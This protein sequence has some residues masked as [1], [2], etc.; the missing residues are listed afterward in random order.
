MR[1][2]T[3]LALLLSFALPGTVGAQPSSPAN[4]GDNAN[5]IPIYKSADPPAAD[6]YLRGNLLGQRC[7][8]AS[9][10]IS[11]INPD[12]MMIFCND[13]RAT[14]NFDDALVPS[15]KTTL[16][17]SAWNGIKTFFAWLTGRPR[18]PDMRKIIATA[19]A[20]VGGG[21]SYD[22][23]TTFQ[24]FM[25][26]GGPNDNTP[27]SLGHPGKLLGLQGYSDP[28]AISM[29]DGRVGVAYIGFTRDKVTGEHTQSAIFFTRYRDRNASDVVHDWEYEFTS[30]A[31]YSKNLKQGQFLDKVSAAQAPDGTLY[32]AFTRFTGSA[33]SANIFLAQSVDGGLTWDSASIDKDAKYGQ[34]AL[35]LVNPTDASSVGVLWRTFVENGLLFKST[36]KGTKNVDLFADDPEG[37]YQPFDQ[38]SQAVSNE[39]PE[40]VAFRALAFPAADYTPDGSRLV[41]VFTEWTDL[42]TGLPGTTG[43]PMPMTVMKVSTDQGATWSGRYVLNVLNGEWDQVPASPERLGFFS[44]ARPVGAQMMPAVSCT[45]GNQ[46]LVVWKQSF[47]ADLVPGGPENAG[48]LV[49]AG[50][51]RRFDVRGALVT[52]DGATPNV[53]PSFQISRYGYR[54]PEPNETPDD[55]ADDDN[56]IA[57]ME[58][59]NG[60][61]YPIV[62]DGNRNHTGGGWMAFA[63][64]YIGVEKVRGEDGNAAFMVAF[65]DNRYNIWPWQTEAGGLVPSGEEWRYYPVFMAPDDPENAIPGVSCRNY[66]S[67]V[68]SVMAARVN[69]SELLL[70]AP[71]NRKPF[72]GATPVCGDPTPG[73]TAKVDCIEFPLSVRNNAGVERRVTLSLSSGSFAKRAFDPSLDDGTDYPYPL[74]TGEVTIY[75]YSSYSLN[76]YAFDENPV[77]VTA[78]AWNGPAEPAPG[79]PDPAVTATATITFN[80]PAVRAAS[81][82]N[83]SFTYVPSTVNIESGSARSGSARSGSA[84]SGSAR[85]GSARSGSARSYPVPEDPVPGE[86]VYDV[87]DY[88]YVVTANSPDDAGTYLSLFNIDPAYEG[89]YVFQVFVTKPLTSFMTDADD[90]CSAF[91]WTEG[92]LI[93]HISDPTNPLVSGSARSGSA[94][95]GSARSGSARSGSARSAIPSEGDPLV[96]NT[97]FTLGSSTE[98]GEA[99]ASSTTSL[100][101]LSAAEET[102]ADHCRIDLCTLAAPRLPNE[103]TILVR[104]YQI[105]PDGD[106][107]VKYDPDGSRTSTPTPPSVAVAEYSCDDPSCTAA[108]G[109]D[110]VVQ[111]D[112]TPAPP[113][114]PN[115]RVRAGEQVSFP[116]ITITNQGVDGECGTADDPLPCGD[117]RPHEWAVYASTE[118]DFAKVPR[119]NCAVDDCDPLSGEISGTVKLNDDPEAGPV[120]VLL[121][122]GTHEVTLA[123]GDA[124]EAVVGNL[125]I[126]TSL[127][128]TNPDGTG[129][130]SL[131]FYDDR[132]RIVNELD[133]TNNHWTEGPIIVEA[134]GYGF[135]GLQSPCSG[136]TCDKTG[137]LPLAWQFTDGS[138]PIDSVSTL[139]RLKFYGG[140]PA[141]LGPDGY[142]SGTILASSSPDP[143]DLT[144][145]A[146]G[147]QYFPDP[148]MVRLQYTWQFNFD[149]TGLP[150]GSC[151]SMY[152]AVPDTGQVI[153]S[154]EEGLRPFGPFSITPR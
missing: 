58:L 41:A 46:C 30:M 4:V 77:T 137:T 130:Y 69:T 65:S 28:F 92:A 94:R 68:Q 73:S 88:T 44:P 12:H 23:G 13:Y 138:T 17:A 91:N 100:E 81:A 78:T 93:G 49:T 19:E 48:S 53:S 84:R 57:K 33:G 151:Y 107:P 39:D 67:R 31:G 105:K 1:L 145:G 132:G 8:E 63:G 47:Q 79:E 123:V 128:R 141:P 139:P 140:C 143:T 122:T 142:P 154:T 34:A 131:H 110:L 70:N 119:W 71:T 136:M 60:T 126:P 25:V 40:R 6:D 54:Q 103:V 104:A 55:V 111:T 82:D 117:A 85:S 149:A 45:V 64:D 7:N 87:I 10:G 116:D 74:Q 21:V 144:S 106:I 50:L 22:G 118:P 32:I 26:P 43:Y 27:A 66:G 95:S 9:I 38:Y 115:T 51:T 62:D 5:I 152:I 59:P 120:T 121:T 24:G 29:K 124:E 135:L 97:S 153:G 89:S 52:F 15:G 83:P 72:E 35:P 148:G 61:T 108:L 146:S 125:T 14:F 133:E 37:P 16:I 129:T 102:A 75:P 86:T 3:R 147:W 109:P 96:Q 113:I 127:P 98:L 112:P 42:G 11:S 101:L 36:S 20:G 18:E 2:T 114:V 134:P 80:D 90:T 99:S 150:R 76:V 56:W